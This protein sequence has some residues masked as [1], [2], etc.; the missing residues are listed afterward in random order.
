MNIAKCLCLIEVE[1]LTGQAQ[2][3]VLSVISKYVDHLV[4]AKQKID[5]LKIILRA[6]SSR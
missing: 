5:Q 1:T 4:A 6:S 2:A 3:L